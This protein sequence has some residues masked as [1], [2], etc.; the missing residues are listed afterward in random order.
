MIFY[1]MC[2]FYKDDTAFAGVGN[3][4]ELQFTKWSSVTGD[5]NDYD[6]VLDPASLKPVSM[7]ALRGLVTALLQKGQIP[8]DYA[9]NVMEFPNA[10]EVAETMKQEMELAAIGKVKRP[11]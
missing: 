8:L 4:G 6:I 7:T 10:S 1:C 11:R 2:S 5:H 3:R 9:L